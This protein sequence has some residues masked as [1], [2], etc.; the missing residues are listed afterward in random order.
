MKG[1]IRVAI[2]PRQETIMVY[3]LFV[4]GVRIMSHEAARDPRDESPLAVEGGSVLAR[5]PYVRGRTI[6][7]LESLGDAPLDFDGKAWR[8][9]RVEWL[10]RPNRCAFV[11]GI[12][13]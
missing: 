5:S 10:S 9:L 2:L 4:G 1:C 13:A 3:D 12:P 8:S 11:D 6:V 7:E